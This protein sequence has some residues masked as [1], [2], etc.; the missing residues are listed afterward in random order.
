[1]QRGPS[2]VTSSARRLSSLPHP[3]CLLFTKSGGVSGRDPWQSHLCTHSAAVIAVFFLVSKLV[4]KGETASAVSAGRDARAR[5]D[6]LA[7]LLHFPKVTL[8]LKASAV[9]QCK[10]MFARFPSFPS[11]PLPRLGVLAVHWFVFLSLFLQSPAPS[12]LF[13]R[14]LCIFVL[15]RIRCWTNK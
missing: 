9:R 11:P 1:M 13:S 15:V 12:V 4:I 5:A 3:R 7:Q 14:T 8:I 6:L 10:K 2:R